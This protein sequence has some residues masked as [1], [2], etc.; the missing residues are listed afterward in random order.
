M[1]CILLKQT[2]AGLKHCDT[3]KNFV[4]VEP[5]VNIKIKF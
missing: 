4:N 3:A 1:Q 5:P 2:E